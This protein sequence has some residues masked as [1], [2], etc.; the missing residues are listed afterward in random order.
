MKKVQEHQNCI[1]ATSADKFTYLVSGNAE[2][3]KWMDGCCF[4]DN[5]FHGLNGIENPPKEPG[6]YRATIEVWFEQGYYEGYKADGESDWEFRL[7]NLE[8]IDIPNF[9]PAAMIEIPQEW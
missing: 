5:H 9:E 8:R 6:V 2:L 1:L 7:G 3:R 4:E